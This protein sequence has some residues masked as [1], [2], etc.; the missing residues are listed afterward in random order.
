MP[1]KRK[2]E[3]GQK[4]VGP[5]ATYDKIKDQRS[6]SRSSARQGR[7]AAKN[8]A[9]LPGLHCASGGARSSSRRQ[10]PGEAIAELRAATC[11]AGTA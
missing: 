10:H 7:R 2:E 4:K 9:G 6:L 1:Y 5:Q 11:R 8:G 3:L